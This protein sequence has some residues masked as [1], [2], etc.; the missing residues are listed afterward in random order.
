MWRAPGLPETPPDGPT[1]S[2]YSGTLVAEGTGYVHTLDLSQGG[3]WQER[4]ILSVYM[5]ASVVSARNELLTISDSFGSLATV[6]VL[7]LGTFGVK[8]SFE[9][10]DDE[11]VGRVNG[12]AASQDGA[13]LAALLEGYGPQYLEVLERSGRRVVYSGLD[14]VT[15]STMLWTPDNKLVFVMSIE[16]QGDPERWGAI[17]AVPLERFLASSGANLEIDL[18]A[19]FTRAE[20]D[21]GIGDLAISKDGRQLAYTRGRDVWVM[22]FAQGATPHQLTTGSVYVGGTQF[23]PDASALAVSAGGQYGLNE[24]YII[25]NHWNAPVLLDYGQGAGNEYLTGEDTLVDA[26]LVWLL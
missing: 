17:G 16:A 9:W 11:S 2:P 18:Y 10:S 6:E 3:D 14:I 22:D 12:L 1:S 7:D 25:P 26:V 20:W 4:T 21:A 5:A 19:I 23:S 15:D 24:T 8:E 13:Y